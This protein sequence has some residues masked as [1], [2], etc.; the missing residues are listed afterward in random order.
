M[1]VGVTVMKIT[2]PCP[3]LPALEDNS[4]ATCQDSDSHPLFVANDVPVHI[5]R[6]CETIIGLYQHHLYRASSAFSCR[7]YVAPRGQ[8][9]QPWCASNS[10]PATFLPTSLASS[11]VLR[12]CTWKTRASDACRTFE[13]PQLVQTLIPLNL[14]HQFRML[15]QLITKE[16]LVASC[17]SLWPARDA[18]VENKE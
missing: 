2:H 18:N 10:T 9:L 16:L 13:G 11:S 15:Q 7:N 6:C 1:L 8:A 17:A 12:C 5:A 3:S 4:L 14:R